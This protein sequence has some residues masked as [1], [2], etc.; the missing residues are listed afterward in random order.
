[1]VTRV[2][3]FKFILDRVL[4]DL[5]GYLPPILGCHPGSMVGWG[6]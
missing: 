1:M 2:G 4:F 5:E 6:Y 3:W